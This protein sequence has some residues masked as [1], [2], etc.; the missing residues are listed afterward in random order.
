MADYNELSR[1]IN[2]SIEAIMAKYKPRIEA[3]QQRGEKM[4]D[5]FKRPG[6][7]GIV[8]GVDLD[9]SWKDVKI[10]FDVPSVAIKDQSLKFD[11]P[12]TTMKLQTLSWDM[13][14]ICME[15]V[16]IGPIKFHVPKPCMKR[17]EIKLHL[18]EFRMTTQE[19]VMGIPEFRMERVHWTIGLPQI[20]V[21][22]VKA[23]TER[24]QSNGQQL[25]AEADALANEMKAEVDSALELAYGGKAE[26]KASFDD[27][28][29]KL[30]QG[31]ESTQQAGIDPIKV[32]TEEGN[33]N[34]RKQYEELLQKREQV[35]AN[36]GGE[37][38][39]NEHGEP[40]V[41]LEVVAI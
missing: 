21:R 33:V 32:P 3:L 17:Q 2:S 23:E 35:L 14:A 5:D 37:G 4:K 39:R 22:N 1:R 15:L 41:R 36:L 40:L 28:L 10:I 20:T 30:Q 24:L 25:Q 18:P 9:V 11:L 19:I 38:A 6:D 12:E 31:I 13:P 34:L 29:F 16:S 26:V 8:I 27:T 7:L